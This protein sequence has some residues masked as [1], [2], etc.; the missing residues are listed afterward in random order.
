MQN[1]HWHGAQVLTC[2]FLWAVTYSLTA[3]PI[4]RDWVLFIA[5][6][7]FRCQSNHLSCQTAGCDLLMTSDTAKR[8]LKK[9]LSPWW[10][11]LFWKRLWQIP[12]KGLGYL[13]Q[14]HAHCCWQPLGMALSHT[15]SQGRR[16]VISGEFSTSL[17][18]NVSSGTPAPPAG[19]SSVLPRL[20]S[21]AAGLCSEKEQLQAEHSS[22]HIFSAVLSWQ[23]TLFG[24]SLLLGIPNFFVK[25][26][27]RI[28]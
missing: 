15:N 2:C 25:T 8:W 19:Q 4:Q 26:E 22:V 16:V 13:C 12:L 5:I 11:G 18:T 7:S 9:L 10:A 3:K 6:L 23:R 20:C 14:C 17:L 27:K 1:G 24:F 28:M 21:F